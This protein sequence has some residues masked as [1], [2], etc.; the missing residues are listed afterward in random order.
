[1]NL[2]LCGCGKETPL[3]KKTNKKKGLVKGQPT[4][5]CHNHHRKYAGKT[6][7]R[8][9]GGKTRIRGYVAIFKPEHP[10]AI[11]GRYVYEQIL[12]AEKALGKPLPKG[13]LVH[14]VNENPLDNRNENLVIC[15]GTS[16]HQFLHLRAKKLKTVSTTS[17]AATGR[18]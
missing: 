15:E 3:A 11:K 13:A 17:M 6:H 12:I 18:K 1:M 10:R 5:Y 2:C 7:P 8:W 9:N 16:Y 4:R 14:H